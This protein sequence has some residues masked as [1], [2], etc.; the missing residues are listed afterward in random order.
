MLAGVDILAVVIAGLAGTVVITIIMS[1]APQ[2][3]MPTMDMPAML[4]SMLSA[5]GSWSLGLIMHLMM[6]VIF[7]FLYGLLWANGIGTPTFLSAV[8]FGI[9][10]WLVV[11]LVM[12]TMPLVHAGIKSGD[13]PEPGVYM[14]KNGGVMGFMG[15]MV[16]HII[17]ALVVVI[18]YP[19]I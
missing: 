15:G 9:I 16:G 8:L 11:G 18:L 7:T 12:G 4:G 19:L 5:P 6:G 1:L 10:H 17:F 14:L 3:G 13:V 2:M